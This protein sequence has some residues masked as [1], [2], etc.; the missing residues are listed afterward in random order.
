M[1]VPTPLLKS[2]PSADSSPDIT[3]LYLC[4]L[5]SQVPA[6]TWIASAPTSWAHFA[7]V[8]ASSIVTPSGTSSSA[9]NLYIKLKS[10][11]ACFFMDLIV[12]NAN[13][14]LFSKLP[15]YLSVL[16]LVYP[17]KNCRGIYP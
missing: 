6:D 9:D 13:L 3:L 14:A 11:P 2:L 8:Q 1:D 12:S 15:P 4:S 10:S 16:L 7:K 5:E 17:D